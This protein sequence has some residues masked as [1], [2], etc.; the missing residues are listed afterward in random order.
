M[1]SCPF[2]GSVPEKLHVAASNDPV[3]CAV[4]GARGPDGRG[5]IGSG[6]SGWKTRRNS[7]FL[8]LLVGGAALGGSFGGILGAIVGAAV[9]GIFGSILSS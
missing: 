9:G 3:S 1:T 5:L 2:C 4:C 7:P 6:H 8:L